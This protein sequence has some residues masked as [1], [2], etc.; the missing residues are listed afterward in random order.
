MTHHQLNIKKHSLTSYF[1]E[2]LVWRGIKMSELFNGIWK[3]VSFKTYYCG[4]RKI[5]IIKNGLF[6]KETLLNLK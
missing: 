6:G 5:P 4:I 3:G 2:S 1:K